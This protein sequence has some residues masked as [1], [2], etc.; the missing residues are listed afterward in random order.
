MRAQRRDVRGR[1]AGRDHHRDRI[2]R[3]DAQENEDDDR[4]P[5]QRDGGHRQAIKRAGHHSP[6]QARER[7]L[8]PGVRAPRLFHAFDT[9]VG[10]SAPVPFGVTLSED[11]N[12]IGWKYCTSGST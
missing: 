1:S 4:D 5:D 3:N 2:A 9:K 12:T 6:E 7:E 10:C 8:A 11:L